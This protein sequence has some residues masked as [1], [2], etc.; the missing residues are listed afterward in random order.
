ME[1]IKIDT[2]FGAV[3]SPSGVLG[4]F[5]ALTALAMSAFHLYTAG[6]GTLTAMLQRSLHLTFALV[7]CYILF[8]LRKRDMGR[9]PVYDLVIAAVAALS[10][11]YTFIFYDDLVFRIGAPSRVDVIVGIVAIVLTLE[12]GRRALGP[13][14]PVVALAFI[15]YCFVGPYLPEALAHRGYS[16]YRVIDH[17]YLTQEGLFGVPLGVSST[18]VFLFVLFGAFMEAS[19]AGDYLIRVAF[20]GLGHAR[21]GPAKVSVVGSGLLGSIVGSSVANVV[22]TGSLTIPI[23]KKTGFPPHV[24]GAV[25]VAA[26]TNGQFLPPVMGAAAFVMAEVTGI[27]YLEICKAALIP[28]VLSYVA[29]FGM[30]HIESLKRGITGM[31]RSELPAFWPT[32]FGGIHYWIPVV[33]L[34]Y[35]LIFKR[36]TPLLAAYDSILAV[37]AVN[38]LFRIATLLRLRGQAQERLTPAQEGRNWLVMVFSAMENGA[39]NMAGI[40]VACACAGIVVGAITLTGL[41]LKM[42]DIITS[43]AGGRLLP[44]LIFASIVSIILGMGLP[45]TAKYVV[46]ATLVVPAILET[47]PDLPM[48]A[49]HLFILY[50]AVLADDTPPVGVAAYAA[51]GVAHSD[52]IKTGFL[53]FK[54]DLAAFLLPF[55]FIYNTELLMIDTHW[56][57][58]LGI[59]LTSLLGMY[60]FSAFVQGHLVVR[61]HWWERLVLAGVGLALVKPGLWT[62]IIGI[63]LFALI[64]FGQ[65]RR[66][67]SRLALANS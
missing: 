11:L 35:Y 16:L 40:A 9:V 53:G 22:T 41:G 50:Y 63:G 43:A 5:L 21:G 10:A 67:K 64:Y 30:I 24:A 34:V 46:M 19:G 2:E 39:K 25:E 4:K 57:E 37:L 45:T 12:A 27:S 14:L 33:I 61:T 3:R 36:V 66:A 17:L 55:M 15:I 54:F 47:A 26:S 28:A 48:V 56:Y 18:F 58:T 51:A 31:P 6:A 59:A 65:Q 32:L 42:T 1:P 13:V 7:L 49:P 44:T 23:M 29:I 52:P 62:D 20:A 38:I 60:A 8:P